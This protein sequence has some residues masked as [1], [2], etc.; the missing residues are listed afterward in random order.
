MKTRRLLLTALVVLLVLPMTALRAEA[1]KIKTPK[2]GSIVGQV[3][4]PAGVPIGGATV[5]SGDMVAITDPGGL[6]ELEDV[7]FKKRVTVRFEA[8]GFATTFG[9]IDLFDRALDDADSDSDSD[10]DSGSDSDTDSDSGSDSDTD[11]D[12]DSGKKKKKEKKKTI[13]V[14]HNQT[15][16]AAGAPQTVN[17]A[18]GGIVVQGGFKATFPAGALGIAGDVQVVISPIDVS[19]SE[20]SAFPGDFV[21]IQTSGNEALM[22]TFSLMDVDIVDPATGEPVDLAPG[23]TAQ[24]EFLLPETTSLAT[25]DTV[26]L[27][28]FDDAQGL[29]LEEGVGTVAASTEV[30]ARLAVFGEVAHFSWWNCDRPIATFNCFTGQVVDPGGAPI[31][32]AQVFASGVDYNGTSYDQTDAAGNYCV[33]VRRD[34]T[35]DIRAQ[36]SAGGVVL[37]SQTVQVDTSLPAGV[38]VSCSQGGCT[39]V[40]DLV[41]AGLSCISGDVRDELDNPVPGALVVTTAGPSAITAADG[42]FCFAAPENADVALATAG[43]PAITVTTGTAGDDCSDPAGCTEA[44]LRAAAGGTACLSG[45]VREDFGVP[46]DPVPGAQVDAFRDEAPFDLLGTA[47]SDGAGEFCVEGL[48]PLTPIFLSV[49]ADEP[50]FCEGGEDGFSTGAAGSSCA[51]AN[52]VDVGDVPCFG[53]E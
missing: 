26:G 15:M 14:T 42:S 19:T 10:S 53:G 40:A 7:K 17:G 8:E 16:V 20:L 46:G 12:S 50:F 43:F 49:F 33:N 52:C 36:F 13:T 1:K 24:L 32:G 31:A 38:V 37:D 25:G 34:S 28:F 22:E 9:V 35:V 47:V 44:L 3:V 51:A 2:K 23:A 30:P 48:P 6:Y 29:W 45:V 27:W 11:S 39:G 41:I 18:A 5:S 4:D 21:G